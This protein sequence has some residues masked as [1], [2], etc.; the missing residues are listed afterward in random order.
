MV[1]TKTRNGTS[2]ELGEREDEKWKQ[3]RELKRKVLIGLSFKLGF[4]PI[5]HYFVP[6]FSSIRFNIQQAV[7]FSLLIVLVSVPLNNEMDNE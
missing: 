3:S 5:F 1:P 7:F 4:V 2:N 6:R